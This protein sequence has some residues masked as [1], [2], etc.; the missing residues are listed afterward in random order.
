MRRYTVDIDGRMYTIDVDQMTPDAFAVSVDGRTF[1]AR[2]TGDRD[3]PGVAISP[4]ISS[5]DDA[6]GR[7]T[8]RA[9]GAPTPPPASSGRTASTRDVVPEAASADSARPA[10]AGAAVLAAPMPGV[11][12]EVLVVAGS[13]VQRGDPLLVLEAMKMRNTIRAPRD[14]SVIEVA[15]AAGAHVGSGDPLVRFGAPPG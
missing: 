5:P 4:Q 15:V 11:V 12:L 1:E 13:V 14:A 7:L 6:D 10:R 3:L 2:L 8:G 9:T